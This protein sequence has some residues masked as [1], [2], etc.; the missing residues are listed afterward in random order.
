M[1]IEDLFKFLNHDK[2][3]IKINKG[4]LNILNLEEAAFYSFLIK[5]CYEK[6]K[7]QE[8]KYFDDMIYYF[9]PVEDIEEK[10]NLTPFKQRVILNK[11]EKENLIKIKFGHARKRYV[12]ISEDISMIEKLVFNVDIYKLKKE[13]VSFLS[14]KLSSLNKQ[15]AETSKKYLLDYMMKEKTKILDELAKTK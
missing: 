2:N 15:D 7:N 8:Y 13:L 1:N 14:D 9:V 11:L 4:L 3:C 6:Y 12:A 5:M 10:L